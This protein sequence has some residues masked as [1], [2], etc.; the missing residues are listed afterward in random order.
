[1]LQIKC[2]RLQNWMQAFTSNIVDT[3]GVSSWMQRH[4]RKQ[5]V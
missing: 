4:G 5:R 2:K 3:K 1:M